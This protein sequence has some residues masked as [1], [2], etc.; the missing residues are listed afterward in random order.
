MNTG[1]PW[2]NPN[3]KLLLDIFNGRVVDIKQNNIVRRDTNGQENV[4]R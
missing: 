3:I 4:Q 2:D 1:N